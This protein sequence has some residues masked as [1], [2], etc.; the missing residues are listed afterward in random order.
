MSPVEGST[1]GPMC[2]HTPTH[3]IHITHTHTS[4]IHHIHNH[5]STLYTH[6][7]HTHHTHISHTHN[8]SADWAGIHTQDK[9]KES[10][11]RP[12]PRLCLGQHHT[13]L[14]SRCALGHTEWCPIHPAP[15]ALL[16]AVSEANPV[17]RGTRELYQICL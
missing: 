14:D 6:I 7:T 11:A 2:I 8:I 15:G 17:V 1:Q 3:I 13:V 16:A 4:H 12:G 10:L 5:T 9:D